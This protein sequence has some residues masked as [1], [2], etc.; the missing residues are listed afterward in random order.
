MLPFRRVGG[1][2]SHIPSLSGGLGARSRKFAVHGL[3]RGEQSTPPPSGGSGG[4]SSSHTDMNL[5]FKVMM[6]GVL[7]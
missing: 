1:P 7:G 5:T 4:G 6:L 2:L 3:S